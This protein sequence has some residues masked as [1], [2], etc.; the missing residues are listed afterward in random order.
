MAILRFKDDDFLGREVY[1]CPAHRL[2]MKDEKESIF[3]TGENHCM[4]YCVDIVKHWTVPGGELVVEIKQ[5]AD[6]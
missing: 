3:H 1:F 2:V 4:A 6:I 5:H